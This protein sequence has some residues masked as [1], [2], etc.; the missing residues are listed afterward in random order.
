VRTHLG[1]GKIPDR[2]AQ[3]LLFLG[4][5]QIHLRENNTPSD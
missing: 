2:P 1:L 5:P 3:E 4:Q